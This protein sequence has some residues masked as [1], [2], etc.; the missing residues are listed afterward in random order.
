ML[1]NSG[2]TRKQ[3]FKAALALAGLKAQEWAGEHDVTVQH[4]NSVLNGDRESASLTA[5]VDAFIEQHLPAHA[6]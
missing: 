4:L 3:R 1:R 5:D 2:P 6:A